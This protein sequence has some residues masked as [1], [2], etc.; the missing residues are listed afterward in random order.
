MLLKEYHSQKS[1]FLCPPSLFIRLCSSYL[2]TIYLLAIYLLTIYFRADE[3]R[4]LA[5]VCVDKVKL[6]VDYL[7]FVLRNSSPEVYLSPHVIL[8]L[9]GYTFRLTDIH[10]RESDECESREG[11]ECDDR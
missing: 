6:Y 1:S 11:D 9:E 10:C 5:S 3:V 7:Y 2:P 4:K 8:S